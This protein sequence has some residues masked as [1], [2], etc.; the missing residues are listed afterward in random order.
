MLSR[1][2]FP[3]KKEFLNPEKLWENATNKNLAV[4]HVVE[5][6]KRWATIPRRMRW[7]FLREPVFFVIDKDAYD[8]VDKLVDYFSEEARVL[9]YR[10][11]HISPIAYYNQNYD[12]IIEKARELAATAPELPFRHHI[13]EALYF[14]TRKAEASSF[15][16][17]LSKAIFS[18]FNSRIVLDPSAGWGDRMLGAAA[19]G[20]PVYHGVDP[21]PDMAPAYDEIIKFIRAHSNV[22]ENYSVL[23]EDFLKVQIIP[24]TYDTV[25]TSPPFYD[26]EIYSSD[27]RQSIVGKTDVTSWMNTFF[28]PYLDKAWSALARNG[29][30]ILYIS[31]IGK[32]RFVQDMFN[33][34]TRELNGKFLGILGAADSNFDRVW[35]IWVWKK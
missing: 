10:Q 27:P 23:N 16:I 5:T 31:D 34:I 24:E 26:Y 17:S 20:V 35:P 18:Y 29:Y 22:G 2:S 6:T 19:A 4:P 32:D 28:K 21:N 30:F 1:E 12:A 9:A 3:Y 33:H 11:G 25:F 15:K 8:E 13:R 14:Y 7:E